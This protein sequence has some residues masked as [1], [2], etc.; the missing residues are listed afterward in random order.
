M[1]SNPIAPTR[2]LVI[3]AALIYDLH[4]VT[5]VAILQHMGLIHKLPIGNQ[6]LSLV[7][8]AAVW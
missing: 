3:F 8:H 1:A 2:I 7:V 5:I 6:L 4:G